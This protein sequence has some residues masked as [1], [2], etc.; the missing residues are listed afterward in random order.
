MLYNKKNLNINSISDRKKFNKNDNEK[1]KLHWCK[2][3]KKKMIHKK[4]NCWKLHSE[5]QEKFYKKKCQNKKKN[6]N[7]K[8]VNL[9]AENSTAS[10][11][12]ELNFFI[13][14]D[15]SDVELSDTVEIK[16]SFS[17]YNTAA[18][19]YRNHDHSEMWIYD[20]EFDTHICNNFIKF[21]KIKKVNI[22]LN[23]I[24]RI[25]KIIKYDIVEA[26]FELSDDSLI[27]HIMNQVFYISQCSVNLILALQMK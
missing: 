4:K 7:K 16:L 5:K 25:D 24:I 11:K 27:I 12:T 13:L 14:F 10:F 1:L 18:A 15:L 6:K 26:L 19:V 2:N 17:H 3:C 20:T 21:K 8:S 22:Q 23:K 9:T